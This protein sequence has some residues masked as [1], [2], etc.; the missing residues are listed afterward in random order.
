VTLYREVN[1]MPRCGSC[2]KL[3][4]SGG[5]E[6]ERR[7]HAILFCSD[8]CVRVFDTYKEPRYGEQAVWPESLIR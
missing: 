1:E 5:I 7:E 6:A 8:Q 3:L 2:G 4:T